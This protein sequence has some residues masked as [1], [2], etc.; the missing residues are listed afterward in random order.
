MNIILNSVTAFT[1][2]DRPAGAGAGVRQS[3]GDGVPAREISDSPAR[4]GV[5]VQLSSD[6][7]R[8]GGRPPVT[9]VGIDRALSRE[10]RAGNEAAKGDSGATSGM[11]FRFAPL[12]ATCM[13]LWCFER[14]R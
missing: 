11:R 13:N 2:C 1:G 12:R 9:D 3:R 7:A 8:L 14:R 10:R 5:E 4:I 6:T